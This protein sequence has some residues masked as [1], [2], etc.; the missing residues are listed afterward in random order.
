MTT[1]SILAEF[2][3]GTEFKDIP[4]GIVKQSKMVLLD[5]IGCALGGLNTEKGKIALAFGTKKTAQAEATILGGRGK[6]PAP[7][8]SFV[9]GELFNALDYDVLCAP[10]GHV[11]P[12]VLSAPLAVAE[13]KN[14][15]G[16][17]LILAIA[18]AHEIAQRIS[19]GLVIPEGLSKKTSKQGISVQLPIHG[20]GVNI[21]GGIAGTAKILGLD[22]EKIE[23]AFGT[24]AYM[25]PVPTLIRFTETVPSSMS[26]FASA[27]WI[28][29]AEVTATLL[30]E[31]GYTG[32][33]DVF[34]G[35]F[36]FW[37]SFAADGWDPR[38][39]VDGLGSLWFFSNAIS[40]KEYPCC[41]AM[42]GALDIFMA[43]M[44]KFRINPEDIKEL[45]IGL[46]LLAEFSLWKNRKINNHIDAQ[47]STAYV[48]AVAAH[49]IE[50]GYKWQEKETYTAPKIVE[51][52]KRINIFTPASPNCEKKNSM[53]EVIVQDNNTRE[54]KRYSERDVWP[55]QSMMDEQKLC[56]KFENNV[57]HVLSPQKTEQALH[58]FLSLETIDNISALME[59]FSYP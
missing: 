42:H 45:N 47:F 21:F 39:V 16:K 27:G 12:Y 40:Y 14:A 52:M 28:S 24:G 17:D 50:T 13:W 22:T 44:K 10:S 6:A 8:A 57:A 32:D 48:F 4:D 43:I 59:L 9:N 18:L 20:Y 55:L 49:R 11:T 51:F 2:I 53:V 15:G 31:M 1:A 35:E 23:N 46:N 19:S 38:V 33:R 54:E 34:D 36:A 26:K 5:S 56:E 25:C 7:I 41:G 30:S 3:S 29:Q 37:K 58:A